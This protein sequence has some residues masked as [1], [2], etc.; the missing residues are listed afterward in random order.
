MCAALNPFHSHWIQCVNSV[1][2]DISYKTNTDWLCFGKKGSTLE[3]KRFVASNQHTNLHWVVWNVSTSKRS[4]RADKHGTRRVNKSAHRPTRTRFAV[5]KIGNSTCFTRVTD[6]C[7]LRFSSCLVFHSTSWV[8]LNFNN[9]VIF[10]LDACSTALTND[11]NGRHVFVPGNIMLG[12]VW[13][14][15]GFS[16]SCCRLIVRLTTFT[17]FYTDWMNFVLWLL[18]WIFIQFQMKVMILWRPL[19]LSFGFSRNYV[20]VGSYVNFVPLKCSIDHR[21]TTDFSHLMP[22]AQRWELGHCLG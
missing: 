1:E 13:A 10:S 21:R 12:H 20:K 22:R 11:W 17:P 15:Y 18:L 5:K 14:G 19:L 16:C 6:W 2:A 4:F 3:T 7:D 8:C 9:S